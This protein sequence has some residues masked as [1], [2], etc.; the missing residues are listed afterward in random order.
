MDT[1]SAVLA[2][3]S[4]CAPFIF[5]FDTPMNRIIFTLMI[6]TD[7]K[8]PCDGLTLDKIGGAFGQNDSQR[9]A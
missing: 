5:I 6:Q 7:R 8:A 1:C 2:Y 4:H 9:L 3:A